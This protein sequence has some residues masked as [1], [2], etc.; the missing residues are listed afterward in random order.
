MGGVCR[1]LRQV[2]CVRVQ[3]TQ[4]GAC[5]SSSETVELPCKEVSPRRKAP[6]PANS[7]EGSFRK[8]SPRRSPSIEQAAAHSRAFTPERVRNLELPVGFSCKPREIDCLGML[9][10][11]TVD[12]W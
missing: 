11:N 3:W 9:G 7:Q 6:K 2:R 5:V 10:L 4:M 1:S 8:M 12:I